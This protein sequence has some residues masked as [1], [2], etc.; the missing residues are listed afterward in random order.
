MSLPPDG[1][2]CC[3]ACHKPLTTT[4]GK[5]GLT[6]AECGLAFPLRGGVLEVAT[7]EQARGESAAQTVHQFGESWRIHDHMAAYYERQFLDWVAPLTAS[8]FRG[9]TVLEAGCG[10]GRHSRSVAGWD[11]EQLLSVDL[12]S[13]VYLAAANTAEFPQVS[14][15]RADLL[16]LPFPDGRFDL[17][18]CVGVLHHLADPQAGLRELW[19]VLK[20]GGTLCLWVYAREGNGW[21]VALVDPVRKGITSRIPTRLLRPLVWPLSAFLFLLLKG[22]YGP[23]T[24]RGARAVSWLPY[25]AYLGYISRF[26]FREVEHIVLDHLCPPIAH[27]LRRPT[28]EEWLKC[29][30]AKEIQCRWHNRNSWAVLAHKGPVA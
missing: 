4:D 7:D 3:P 26:P 8:D 13:A 11:P 9:R 18:F 12:S 24:G 28:L 6:C 30:D 23:A 20:P 10:K 2:V 1:W 27:Y 19:R 15:V 21:I 22:L 16:D 17:V 25:G 29:L 14:C 5:E